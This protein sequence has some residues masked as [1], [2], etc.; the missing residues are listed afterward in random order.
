MR[1]RVLF[2]IEIQPASRAFCP[3]M[4]LNKKIS[5]EIH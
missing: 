4:I 5:E 2:A 1:D 3:A